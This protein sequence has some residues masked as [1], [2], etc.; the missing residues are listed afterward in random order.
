MIRIIGGQRW[1][2]AFVGGSIGGIISI[3]I[4]VSIYLYIKKRR[5]ERNNKVNVENEYQPYEE[6]LNSKYDS[7]GSNITTE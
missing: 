6:E 7:E 3:G 1:K 2:Y 4:G 5:Y